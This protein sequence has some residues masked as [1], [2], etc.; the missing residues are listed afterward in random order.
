MIV[1]NPNP[2]YYKVCYIETAQYHTRTYI[3]IVKLFHFIPQ[4]K[5]GESAGLIY[6]LR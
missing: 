2:C 3:F 5:E 6:G 4:G 1:L